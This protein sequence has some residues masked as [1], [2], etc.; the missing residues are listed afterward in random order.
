MTAT[1]TT[2]STTTTT[3]PH[4]HHDTTP[5][6][7]RHSPTTTTTLPHYHHPIPLPP[8]P[9]QSSPLLYQSMWTC[10][11]SSIAQRYVVCPNYVL[12]LGS[13]GCYVIYDELLRPAYFL[14]LR[15]LFNIAKLQEVRSINLYT[16]RLSFNCGVTSQPILIFTLTRVIRWISVSS[17]HWFMRLLL[18]H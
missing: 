7:P 8:P 10:S 13:V 9:T 2:K 17:V 3:L 4:Y 1:L 15:S 18:N 14:L 11:H 12:G 5:L 6:P 16:Q